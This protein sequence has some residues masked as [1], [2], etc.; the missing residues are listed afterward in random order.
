MAR[1]TFHMV[2]LS[3]N[4]GSDYETQWLIDDVILQSLD[5][6]ERQFRLIPVHMMKKSKKY[7]APIGL[8]ALRGL[9]LHEMYRGC[10]INDLDIDSLGEGELDPIVLGRL[11]SLLITH[12][13]ELETRKQISKV[14][15]DSINSS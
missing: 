14:K 5:D 15:L 1:S 3:H 13:N 10:D 9:N 4:F 2:L 6:K 8:R 7:L 11:R 12:K